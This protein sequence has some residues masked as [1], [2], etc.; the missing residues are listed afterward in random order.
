MLSLEFG[1]WTLIHGKHWYLLSGEEDGTLDFWPLSDVVFMKCLDVARY[2][3]SALG[4]NC[5]QCW[6]N[7]GK[8][9]LTPTFAPGRTSGS[10]VPFCFL[11]Q[12][13]SHMPAGQRTG[14]SGL[15]SLPHGGLCYWPTLSQK[16]CSLTACAS[17]LSQRT[18][19]SP[20]IPMDNKFEGLYYKVS[21]KSEK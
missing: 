6:L 3:K 7:L 21:V 4:T 11:L 14:H 10:T 17:M 5:V 18:A 16:N 2:H 15:L 20:S 8:A 13:S 12:P 19:I 1:I 9:C